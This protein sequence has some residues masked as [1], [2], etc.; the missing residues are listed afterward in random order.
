[1]GEWSQKKLRCGKKTAEHFFAS[2]PGGESTHASTSRIFS[3]AIVGSRSQKPS[4]T[5]KRAERYFFPNRKLGNSRSCEF[6]RLGMRAKSRFQAL[7]ALYKKK[8]HQKQESKHNFRSYVT[9]PLIHHV[10]ALC[11]LLKKATPILDTPK[12]EYAEFLAQT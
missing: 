9:K 5:Q 7:S 10:W 12:A 11:P 1:M 3:T 6:Q 4:K 8:T 2:T